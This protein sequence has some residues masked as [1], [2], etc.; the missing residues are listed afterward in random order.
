M[1]EKKI[2][3]GFM[4]E[5]IGDSASNSSRNV[6]VSI[7]D[8]QR[9]SLD[10]V[11]TK[12]DTGRADP[13]WL[14]ANLCKVWKELLGISCDRLTKVSISAPDGY[15][16]VLS[17][18][19]LSAI[20]T[21]LCAYRKKGDENFRE[22]YGY[23]RLIYPEL[24]KM[25]WVNEPEKMI[26]ELGQTL[27]SANEYQFHFQQSRGKQALVRKDLKS[28][29]YLVLD[30][31]L[32]G[33]KLLRNGFHIL[34]TDKLFREYTP[35]KSMC[36]MILQKETKGTWKIHGINVPSG[37]KTRRIFFMVSSNKGLFLKPLS[38]D[39]Q[40]LWQNLFWEPISRGI[41]AESD[42]S[43]ELVLNDGKRIISDL[44]KSVRSGQISLYNLFE[45]ELNTHSNIDHIVL[46]WRCR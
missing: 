10:S 35:S 5:I 32:S 34:T 28:K 13:V 3:D 12:G 17:G 4:V 7:D 11:A 14:G 29:P 42:W 36:K 24:R 26:V 27:S 22:K 19:L 8:I 41:P 15:M 44:T 9:I 45:Q 31:V 21:A 33:L 39:E 43:I 38:E 18:E 25:Y 20:N 30:D 46:K 23:I 16:S 2:A 6:F 1:Q 37:L 40:I